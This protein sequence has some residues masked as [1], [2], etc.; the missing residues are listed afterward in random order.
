MSPTPMSNNCA[1][2][3]L[4]APGVRGHQPGKGRVEVAD[5]T[6]LSHVPGLLCCDPEG[7]EVERFWISCPR[8]VEPKCSTSTKIRFLRWKH[9]S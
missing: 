2:P 7:V 4:I 3:R 9:A 6:E 1:R 8:A 5:E